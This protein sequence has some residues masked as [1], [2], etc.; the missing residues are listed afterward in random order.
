MVTTRFDRIA[1]FGK[2]GDPVTQPEFWARVADD[3]EWTVQGTHPLAGRYHSKA[4]FLE[5]TFARLSGVLAGGVKL[6]VKH[7][8]VDGDITIAELHSVSMTN[9]GANFAND[10]CWV[11]RFNGDIIVEVH[12]YLDSMMVSY[13]I[14]RN[15]IA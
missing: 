4:Q 13:R 11:C 14:L 9:E 2:L 8:L 5:A 3:V 6:E 15:E 7:L 1:L 12:A 10:Y